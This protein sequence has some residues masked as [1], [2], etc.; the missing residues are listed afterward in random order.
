VVQMEATLRH[1]LGLVSRMRSNW[2]V[3]SGEEFARGRK[4]AVSSSL[5][6][7]NPTCSVSLEFG[8]IRK[9]TSIDRGVIRGRV[10]SRDDGP[11]IRRSGE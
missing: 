7:M 3:F 11:W 1:G 9:P 6:V 5:S 4:L 2:L 10:Q 8:S